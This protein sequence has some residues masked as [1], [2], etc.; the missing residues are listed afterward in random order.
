MHSLPEQVETLGLTA[1]HESAIAELYEEYA[2]RFA[3]HATFFRELAAEEKKHARLIVSFADD[4]KRHVV[5]VD[6]DRFSSISILESVDNVRRRVKDAQSRHGPSLVNALSVCADLENTMIE[7]RYFDVIQ[8][9][10]PELVE[11]LRA[12]ETD[13]EAHRD[14]VRQAL[15]RAHEAAAQD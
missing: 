15:A 7:R 1:A 10:G 12:L 4:V 5:Q 8:G 9:D 11:L 3:E 14:K 6:P 13:S 2:A